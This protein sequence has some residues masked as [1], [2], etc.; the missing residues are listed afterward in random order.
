M[1]KSKEYPESS[2]KSGVR[3]RKFKDER[4]VAAKA[5]GPKKKRI[6]TGYLAK[7]VGKHKHLSVS[8]GIGKIV[9]GRFYKVNRDIAYALKQ[10]KDWVV[11]EECKFADVT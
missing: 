2:E 1:Y 5:I 9:P 3:A 7:Y 4:A 6:V 10:T 8:P 11:K